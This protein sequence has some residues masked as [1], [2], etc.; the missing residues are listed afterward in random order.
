ME[1]YKKKFNKG[2]EYFH[3]AIAFAKSNRFG[4]ELT[5]NMIGLSAEYLLTS[6]LTKSE[7]IIYDAGISG[8]LAALKTE[9]LVPESVIIETE[10]L[11]HYCSVCCSKHEISDM[12][13][14]I[15]ALR[16]I[17]QWSELAIKTVLS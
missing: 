6:V 16:T 11:V 12:N 10:K 14:L 8:I 13:E 4:E 15:E 2:L 5:L 9:S 17:K 7:V 1:D 3:N